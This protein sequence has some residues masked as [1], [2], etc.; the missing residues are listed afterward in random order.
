MELES[1]IG[2]EI[3]VQL[4]TKSKMFCSCD[5]TGELKPVN[6]TVCPVCLGQPG[7]L[8]VVNADAVKMGIKAA[9]ALNLNVLLHSKFDRK[10]YF[11]PDLPKGYQISQ[12]DE[13]LARNGNLEIVTNLGKRTIGI[14]RLHLEEDTGKLL[15]DN[16]KTLVDFNRAGTP[17]ME[18]VTLPEV[19]EPI[20]AK[21]FLQDLRSI[22]KTL[23]VSDADMEKGH[24]RVDVNISLRPKGDKKLYAKTELKNLNSFRSVERGLQYEIK[25]LTDLWNKNQAPTVTATR[26]W[27]ENKGVSEEQ[28]VKEAV[29]DYRY[30]PEPDLPPLNF[31]KREIDKVKKDLPELPKVK[32]ARFVKIYGLNK[33]D[34]A[35]LVSDVFL[36]EFF[37]SVVNQLIVSADDIDKKQAAKLAASWMVNKLF[38]LLNE[39]KKEFSEIKFTSSQF[40]DF[41]LMVAGR[42]VNSTNALLLLKKMLV[43]GSDPEQILAEEDLSQHDGDITSFIDTVIGKYPDQVKQFKSGKEPVIKFLVGAVMKESKGKVNPQEAEKILREKIAS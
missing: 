4:K 8:P 21:T 23:N 1:V 6:S 5:N 27:D 11:Y 24:L 34:A 36:S 20:E 13:P 43:T 7:T 14:D 3:H 31:T 42:R 18:I 12:F 35:V 15:H 10:N 30:F 39:Q 9:L 19:M 22:L 29:H 26:G 41:L 2:L 25:R 17:L 28:R 40:S 38:E 32:A 37:E 16:E 33:V